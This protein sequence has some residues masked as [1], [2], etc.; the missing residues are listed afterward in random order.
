MTEREFDLI[1]ALKR[2]IRAARAEERHQFSASEQ[3]RTVRAQ[4]SQSIENAERVLK[5][6]E[7]K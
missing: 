3:A 2:L 4:F 1:Q 7:P 6:I 5:R